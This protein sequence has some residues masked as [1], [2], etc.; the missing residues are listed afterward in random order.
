LSLSNLVIRSSFPTAPLQFIGPEHRQQWE[1]LHE[2]L[3]RGDGV[4]RLASLDAQPVGHAMVFFRVDAGV[5]EFMGWLPGHLQSPSP[6]LRERHSALLTDLLVREGFRL[7]GLGTALVKDAMAVARERGF[8]SLTL[9]VGPE[10][11]AA[12]RL[13]ERLGFTCVLH[14]DRPTP[15]TPAYLEYFMS[16]AKPSDG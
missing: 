9:H 14:I 6:R 11:D 8:R 3:Q 15:T 13:Y 1:T 7:R 10:N 5:E 16:L 2:I 12:I 4:L